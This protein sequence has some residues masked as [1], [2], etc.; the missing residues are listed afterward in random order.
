MRILVIW[1]GPKLKRMDIWVQ[2]FNRYFILLNDK[3]EK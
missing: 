3:A 1:K 2:M